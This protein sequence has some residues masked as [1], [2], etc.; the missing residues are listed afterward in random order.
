MV[1][2]SPLS[3]Q[4]RRRDKIKNVLMAVRDNK[5]ESFND[6]LLAFYT[7]EDQA[8]SRQA[9]TSLGYKQGQTYALDI[10]VKNTHGESQ[11]YL[12]QVITRK[13]SEILI[14]ESDRA[15]KEDSLHVS[16]TG[17]TIPRLTGDFGLSR[18]AELYRT[19]L[20]CMWLLLF[21]LLTAENMYEWKSHRT[22]VN[23]ETQAVQ[24]VVVLISILLY[25][26]NRATDA[27]QIMMGIFLASSGASRRVVDTLNHMGL[28]V[29]YAARDQARNFV[30]GALRL[31]AIVYDNINFTLRKASQRLDSATQ[32]LNATTSAVFS[33][34]STIS[35]AAYAAA[36]SVSERNRRAFLRERLTLEAL[37][38]SLEK[39]AH[40]L[41]VFR[42]HVATILLTHSAEPLSKK[43]RKRMLKKAGFMKPKI[44]IISSEKTEF[45]PLPAL[46]QEEASVGGTIKV[47]TKLFTQLLG[48][49]EEVVDAELRLL[50]G[51]WLTIRNLRLMK[52]EIAEETT[53]FRRMSWV[54]EC[55]M[56]FHFQLNAMYMLFRTHLGYPGDNN[57]SSLEHHRSLLRCSK[58]DP[59]K[60][61]YNKAKELLY[62]SVI[63]RVL[64]CA[65][66][67]LG[68]PSHEDLRKW[69]FSWNDILRITTDIMDRFTTTSEAHKHLECGDDI[70]AHAV[71]FL[72]DA[73]IFLEFSDAI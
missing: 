29:S 6:F 67:C 72:Q 30:H 60:P 22:K 25:V 7:S 51:D 15:L 33:L 37:K 21:A 26:R 64:D 42:Y 10:W 53:A 63:A 2:E 14:S 3:P 4:A 68:L 23:K 18:L 43:H 69:N 48:L 73:L 54:Q 52:S 47:V 20:P 41:Q 1:S 19:L 24:I 28:S 38:P 36:L 5:W 9:N 39:Q 13:A 56:P 31:F 17:A 45:Y 44:R 12:K 46:A 58:L 32:Q 35:R 27:F 61:E 34:P 40:L 62:H 65:R 16:A 66:V 55:A 8:I 49:A 57:L 70:L 11:Q 50:V 59:K 71:L